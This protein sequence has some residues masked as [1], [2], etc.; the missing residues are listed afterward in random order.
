V[1]ILTLHEDV[2]LLREAIQA[3]ASGYIIKRAVDRDLVAAIHACGAA[4]SMFTPDMTQALLKDMSPLGASH[5]PVAVQLTRREI[6]VLRLI[7]K[8]LHQSPDRRQVKPQHGH[9]QQS[10]GE[11]DEQARPAQSGRAGAV[12]DRTRPPRMTR[13]G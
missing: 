6:E 8:G 2:S 10:P 9:G 7:V 1:L 4:T 5:K 3:G 13:Q 11:P 12:C